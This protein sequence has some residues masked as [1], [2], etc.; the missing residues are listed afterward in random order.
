MDA[1]YKTT[2]YDV[3]LYF[4]CVRTNVGY[5]T[6]A[7]FVVQSE[8]KESILKAIEILKE[9][10]SSWNPLLLMCEYSEAEMS[11]FESAF[12]LASVFLCDFH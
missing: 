12:P 2:H 4:L 1:T 6:V 9:W 10:N 5:Q 11:A 3:P 7:K 8:S